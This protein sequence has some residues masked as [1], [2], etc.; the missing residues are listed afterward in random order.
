MIKG[1]DDSKKTNTMSFFKKAKE[2]LGTYRSVGLSSVKEKIHRTNLSLSY[3]QI[4]TKHEISLETTS[5][6]LPRANH[7]WSTN[8]L[9]QDELL[10]DQGEI[11]RWIYIR[12]KHVTYKDGLRKLSLLLL[13]K[14][15]LWQDPTAIFKY[16]EGIVG[17]MELDSFQKCRRPRYNSY[18]LNQWK[19]S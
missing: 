10:C 18:K 11:R 7:L 8:C 6:N 19:T 15:R 13:K 17:K 12:R 9:P 5:R 2:E 14:K 1:L 4:N 16:L 3:V